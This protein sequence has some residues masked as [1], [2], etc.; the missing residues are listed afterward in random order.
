LPAFQLLRTTEYYYRQIVFTL[1]RT[2]DSSCFYFNNSRVQSVIYLYRRADLFIRTAIVGKNFETFSELWE[3]SGVH[4][5]VSQFSDIML[6]SIS[7]KQ[8]KETDKF[9]F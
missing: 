2:R 5:I 7:Q 3:K 6:T 4:E 9:F 8:T 1:R